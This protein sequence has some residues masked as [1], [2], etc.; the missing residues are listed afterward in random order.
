MRQ[1]SSVKYVLGQ[2]PYLN[3]FLWLFFITV[4]L[5]IWLVNINLLVYILGSDA[6]A[7]SDKAAMISGAYVNFFLYM[8]NP[9]AISRAIFALL[10]ALN[11]TL[12]IYLWR[13]SKKRQGMARKNGGA[14]VVMV[15]SHC[16]ACGASFVA[17]LVTAIAGSTTYLSAERYAASQLLAMSAYIIGIILILWSI[18]GAAKSIALVSELEDADKTPLGIKV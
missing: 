5:F 15:G 7:I 9:V 17:P 10:I 6:L 8:D 11:T 2:Q 16:I 12:L 4:S 1:Y 14:L 18:R 13:E 3:Y